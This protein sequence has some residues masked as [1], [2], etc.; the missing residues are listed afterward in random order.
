MCERRSQF[1]FANILWPAFSQISFY[2]KYKHYLSKTLQISL[3]Y[4]KTAHKN[5]DQIDTRFP[6]SISS[7]EQ[8]NKKIIIQFECFFHFF[9]S[10][11]FSFCSL[12]NLQN[13]S[14]NYPNQT[15]KGKVIKFD[16]T[17]VDIMWSHQ[18]II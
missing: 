7:F 18:N 8:N 2:R 3:S 14:L 10:L 17:K 5:V 12:N 13:E 15:K 1:Y 6:L 11:Q 4:E 16:F 9:F